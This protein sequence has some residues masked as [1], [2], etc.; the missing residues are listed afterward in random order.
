MAELAA[1]RRR[2]LAEIRERGGARGESVAE[3]MLAVPRHVFVPG[4][5]VEAAYRDDAIIIKRD[6]DG[7]PV[8]SSSQ[9][10]IMA[11]MLDQLGLA[12]GHRVLEVGTG[13][14]YN[15]ALM[16]HLAGPTGVVVSVDIDP[17]VVDQASVSLAAAGYRSVTVVCADG[18]NGYAPAAPYDR[19]IATVGVW[20]LAPAW[21]DQLAPEGRIVVPLDLRG[22]Q[23]SVAFER[24]SEHWVSRSQVACGFMRLRGQSAGPEKVR[25]LDQKTGLVLAV[26]D[27]RGIDAEGIWNALAAPAVIHPTGVSRIGMESLNGLGLWLALTDPR[28]CTL[29]DENRGS[30]VLEQALYRSDDFRGT[31]G[32]L[33]SASIAVLG[34]RSLDGPPSELDARGYGADGGRLAAELTAHVGAWD[35]AGCP[36]AERLQIVAYPYNR[37][38]PAGRVVIE[39]VH[40]RLVIFLPPP[41]HEA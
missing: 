31:P 2:L 5:P 30:P 38:G 39:K 34:R 10:T 37:P 32:I 3:A 14:G 20:D 40:T 41:Q 17:Q 11:L 6:V 15:A 26:P 25:V 13:S 21:L 8:S 18:V 16:A 27:G 9:P 28:S 35:A 23:I 33:N 36:T 19:I 1:L 4:V 29:S 7:L 22:A 24:E 12:P